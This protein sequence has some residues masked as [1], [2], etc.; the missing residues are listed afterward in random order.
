MEV[1]FEMDQKDQETNGQTASD[2]EEEGD[3]DTI[4]EK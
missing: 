4:L 1:S 2:E 3:N